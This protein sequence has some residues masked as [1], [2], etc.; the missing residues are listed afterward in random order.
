[1]M[2]LAT[3]LRFT[4]FPTGSAVVDPDKWWQAVAQGDPDHVQLQPKVNVAE[5]RGEFGEGQLVLGINPSRIDWIYLAKEDEFGLSQTLGTIAGAFGV[6]DGAL[7][8][9]LT[10]PD[11]PHMQRVAFG[12]ILRMDVDSREEGYRAL[13]E[14]LPGMRL[15]ENASDLLYQ[16]NRP[17]VVEIGAQEIEVNRLSRWHVVMAQVARGSVTESIPMLAEATQR[18]YAQVELDINTAPT[19]SLSLRPDAMADVL[20]TFAELAY[21]IAEKGDVP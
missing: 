2:W 4:A 6:F 17:R 16:I 14:F 18:I 1:M 5:F 12:L 21:E 15:S 20:A 13:D 10:R 11:C 8:T 3:Q 19:E 7:R 9:W